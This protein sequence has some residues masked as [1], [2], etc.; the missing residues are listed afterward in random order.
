MKAGDTFYFRK[1]SDTHLWALISDPTQNP[2]CV[3]VVAFSTYETYKDTACIIEQGEHPRIKH[4]TVIWYEEANSPSVATLQAMADEGVI[5]WNVP[6]SAELL[7]RIRQCSFN[8]RLERDH[9]HFLIKQG[10]IDVKKLAR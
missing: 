1:G 5:Q 9:V 7:A 4:K 2:E 8:S 10:L 3:L 6:L